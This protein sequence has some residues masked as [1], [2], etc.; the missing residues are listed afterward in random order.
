MTPAQPQSPQPALFHI[1]DLFA[2][3]GGL[4]IAAKALGVSSIGVEWDT[5]AYATRTRAGLPTVHKD[6]RKCSPTDPAFRGANVLA[7]GPPCQTFTV[8]GHGAG[9]RALD[10][11][12][13]FVQRLVD[14]DEWSNI[15]ADLAE[16]KDERTGLVL[17]PLHWA[18]EAI[19]NPELDP[20][21]A[22]VLEQVPAVLPVWEAYAKALSDE[23]ET[24]FDVLRTEEFGVPQTRKRA[25][26]I[27]R[28][29]NEVGTLHSHH[30]L[31]LP[32]PTHQRYRGGTSREAEG[33]T[34]GDAVP[35][36]WVSM[37]QALPKRPTPFTVISN[38]GTGGDPKARGERRS[39]QPSA[40]VTGKIS[41]NRV[42]GPHGIDRFSFSEAGRLQ[43]FPAEY[44]WSGSDISQ[45]IGNA[46]PPRLGMHIISAALGLGQPSKKALDRLAS[47]KP[48]GTMEEDDASGS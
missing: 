17:Q 3:P 30:P 28:R 10:T 7:G 40:T 13:K 6:V 37:A 14:R 42:V 15:E 24:D 46:V 19:D 38:Y 20:Y 43:T 8:A 16:L 18:L 22:I 11:V 4:D 41:R 26:L 48:P 34:M 35:E 12:L 36:K 32:S 44:P 29:R 25:V 21:H 45:Q 1:V 33:F 5:G 31:R 47:W 23:Y 39:D 9:R 27:A 2:G